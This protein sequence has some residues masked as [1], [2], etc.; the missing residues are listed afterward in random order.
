LAASSSV[1]SSRC[2]AGRPS[3]GW[4]LLAISAQVAGGL[5]IAVALPRL[6]AV[7]TSL[8]LLSQPVASVFLA[9]L[10]VSEA[11]SAIQLAGG[12]R[13]PGRAL[14]RCFGG[15]RPAPE[16]RLRWRPMQTTFR[17]LTCGDARPAHAGR[18]TTL[19]G[20]VHRRRDLRTAHLP[21]PA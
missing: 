19:A 16:V 15:S 17:D 3:A 10:I 6:P 11:P 13:R 12:A 20:W 9:M 2:R 8:L 14:G 1:T 7:N 5:L 18:A 21:R 4:L